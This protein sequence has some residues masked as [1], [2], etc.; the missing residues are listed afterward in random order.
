MT[1]K[2]HRKVKIKPRRAWSRPLHTPFHK[3]KEYTIL[4]PPSCHTASI[5]LQVKKIL[6]R[7]T[8]NFFPFYQSPTRPHHYW[9]LM[10]FQFYW[11]YYFQMTDKTLL[12]L[13][14]WM[15]LGLFAPTKP[16]K[17]IMEHLLGLWCLLF[18]FL[19]PCVSHG[20]PSSSH[21][22][23]WLVCPSGALL[24]FPSLSSGDPFTRVFIHSFN[25]WAQ[26]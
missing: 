26:C 8:F 12:F 10:L 13:K 22:N 3:H 5:F 15:H 9:N 18:D 11:D 25:K 23:S 19:K 16:Q 24:S 20:E 6:A 4:H 7:N 17:S 1:T 21:I 14:C 2:K